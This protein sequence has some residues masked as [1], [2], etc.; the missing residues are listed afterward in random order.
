LYECKINPPVLKGKDKITFDLYKSIDR[1][2]GK[3]TLSD[4]FKETDWC[5]QEINF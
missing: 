3:S 1:D 5:F 2:T 4:Y